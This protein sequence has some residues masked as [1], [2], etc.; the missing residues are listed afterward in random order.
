MPS[1]SAAAKFLQ[2]NIL[3]V[4]F[5]YDDSHYSIEKAYYIL[6]ILVVKRNFTDCGTG[7]NPFKPDRT[8]PSRRTNFSSL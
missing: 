5:F 3:A 1:F 6:E 7:F 2:S 4:A 8:F